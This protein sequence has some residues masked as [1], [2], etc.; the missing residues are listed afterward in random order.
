MKK[1]KTVS[2]VD[3]IKFLSS[4]LKNKRSSVILPRIYYPSLSLGIADL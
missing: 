2:C 3:Y 4:R 1:T